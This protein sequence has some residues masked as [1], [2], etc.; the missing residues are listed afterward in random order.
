MGLKVVLFAG[1]FGLVCITTLANPLIGILGY[2]GHYHVYPEDQWWGEVLKSKG[3]RFSFTI[4]LLTGISFLIHFRKLRFRKLLIAQESLLLIFVGLLW[5]VFFV[6]PPLLEQQFDSEFAP[7]KMTKITV[8]LLMFTHVVVDLKR[9]RYVVWIFII[10]TL[11]LGV[12]AYTAPAG[13]FVDGRLNNIGGPDFSESSFLA[14][15]FVSILPFIGMIFMIEKK[16]W[17]K[18]ICLLSAAFVVNGIILTRTRAAFVGG[19]VGLVAAL[20]LAIPGYRKKILI[21]LILGLMGLPMLTDSGFWERMSTIGAEEQERDASSQSRLDV[22]QATIRLISDHPTGVGAGNFLEY[23]QRDEYYGSRR[24]PHNTY[25]RCFAELGIFGGLVLIAMI[26]NAFWML[27]KVKQNRYEL[28]QSAE[29]RLFAYATQMTLIVFMT[30]GMF[31]SQTYIEEFWWFLLFPVA[32]FR[33]YENAKL[34]ELAYHSSMNHIEDVA[35]IALA[36]DGKSDV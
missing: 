1:I 13:A 32:L 30:C 3:I 23:I 19:A 17:A 10:G 20:F 9:I 7:I 2:L 27:R 33:S 21:L 15:H 5:L 6:E 11:Y 24:D 14:A 12:Q 26:V 25:L 36:T 8:F 18:L 35:Q 28:R 29:Y 22:W 16:W 34:E 31:M 4:A